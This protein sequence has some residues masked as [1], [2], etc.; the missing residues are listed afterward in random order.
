MVVKQITE[1]LGCFSTATLRT[2]PRYTNA[3]SWNQT[4]IVVDDANPQKCTNFGMAA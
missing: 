4:N 3:A 1:T 2:S